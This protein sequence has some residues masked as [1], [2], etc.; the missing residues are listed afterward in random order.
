MDR[1]IVITYLIRKLKKFFDKVP[2]DEK[3][4]KLL[5][6]P[7]EH[8]SD[9]LVVEIHKSNMLNMLFSGWLLRCALTHYCL[10]ATIVTAYY[11]NFV[12]K[13]R[14]DQEKKFLWTPRLWVGRWWEPI[15]GY[16]SKFDGIKVSGINGLK[17]MNFF[18]LVW[19]I[20]A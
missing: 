6:S 14:R 17:K 12:F 19:P 18:E 1:I 16:I 3:I 7:I 10:T 8:I 9:P 11:Q 20:T 5:K 15:L 4:L 13:K 2:Y